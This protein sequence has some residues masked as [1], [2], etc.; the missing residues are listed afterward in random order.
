MD[1]RGSFS[2][3]KL[4]N[5]LCNLA[6]LVSRSGIFEVK[7][8]VV[9]LIAT[10]KLFLFVFMWSW[11]LLRSFS[12]YKVPYFSKK[13]CTSDLDFFDRNIAYFVS[14]EESFGFFGATF[15][16]QFWNFFGG[17][18]FEALSWGIFVFM[19]LFSPWV[20]LFAFKFFANFTWLAFFF[21]SNF[22]LLFPVVF[23]T[24]FA[25]FDPN[26]PSL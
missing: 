23:S 26:P 19:T 22:G 2:I 7:I 18:K 3:S 8:L 6:I 9:S 24:W 15:W 16:R 5:S 21:G 14:K 25:F 12:R 4:F 1:C 11:A 20:Y 10:S 13:D 17:G